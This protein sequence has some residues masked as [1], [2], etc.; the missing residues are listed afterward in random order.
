MGICDDRALEVMS[1]SPFFSP[2][3]SSFLPS[4]LPSFATSDHA[5]PE[6]K[7][8]H[9]NT[10]SIF[11]ETTTTTRRRTAFYV[12]IPCLYISRHQK[13]MKS[14]PLPAHLI[15]PA[16]YAQTSYP[17]ATSAASHVPQRF[18]L[19]SNSP[20][21]SKR[22]LC[23]DQKGFFDHL[24]SRSLIISVSIFDYQYHCWLY[25]HILI[26][27]SVFVSHHL[28]M[29]MFVVHRRFVSLFSKHLKS[30]RAT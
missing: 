24:K 27:L 23:S 28:N 10:F 11:L 17:L 13:N 15:Q 9:F 20:T 4:F 25:R 26:H 3:P 22:E 18:V 8:I 16:S 2:P 29:F 5:P 7:T 12:C 6:K 21:V 30:L 1:I 14:S 19:P